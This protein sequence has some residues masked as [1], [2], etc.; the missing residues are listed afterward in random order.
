ML[1]Q[2]LAA[3]GVVSGKKVAYI[4]LTIMVS[5]R[6]PSELDLLAAGTQRAAANGSLPKGQW[7]VAHV[8]SVSCFL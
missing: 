7:V 5:V 4:G 6:L 8:T 2:H 1:M 3:S